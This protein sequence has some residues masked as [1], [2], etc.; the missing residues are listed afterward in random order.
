MTHQPPMN[1]NNVLLDRTVHQT[2]QIKTHTHTYTHTRTHTPTHAHTHTHKVSSDA[3]DTKSKTII[4]VRVIAIIRLFRPVNT[5]HGIFSHVS[6]GV[7]VIMQARKEQTACL[8]NDR[9]V[10]TSIHHCSP[11]LPEDN[12]SR[13]RFV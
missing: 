12:A 13:V 7:Q 2:I 5:N 10:H 1:R 6:T 3:H 8:S 11:F 9:V 4:M